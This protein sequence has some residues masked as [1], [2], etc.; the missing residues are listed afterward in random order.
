M[1]QTSLLRQGLVCSGVASL[2]S[3]HG[4]PGSVGPQQRQLS[5]S[6]NS[7]RSRDRGLNE[8]KRQLTTVAAAVT[9]VS[10]VLIIEE[11][12]VGKHQAPVA[13]TQSARRNSSRGLRSEQ[14][15]VFR[16][17]PDA[18]KLASK[19]AEGSPVYDPQALGHFY[20]RRPLQVSPREDK[21]L[22]DSR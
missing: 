3:T 13:V 1:S 9:D 7:R 18:E 11:A 21:C 14:D 4:K 19:R 16:D 20:S 10:D 5:K 8:V 12:S 6:T 15:E 17:D 2:S 22:Y